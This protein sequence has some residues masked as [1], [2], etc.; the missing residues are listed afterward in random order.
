MLLISINILYITAVSYY[1]FKY[2]TK[3]E[4]FS[5]ETFKRYTIAVNILIIVE[6]FVILFSIFNQLFLL[7]LVLSAYFS[8]IPICLIVNILSKNRIIFS[9]K[10]AIGINL[11]TLF[12]TSG[13]VFYYSYLLTLNTFLVFVFPLLTLSLLLLLPL[14]YARN[15][16]V[17]SKI[18]EKLLLID[19]LLISGLVICSPIVI[20]LELMRIGMTIDYYYIL[21]TTIFLFFG[22]TRYLEYLFDK[23]KLKEIHVILLKLSQ[24]LIW[25]IASIIIS[26]GIFNL[27]DTITNNL[28]LSGSAFSLTFFLVNLIILMSL[29]NLKQRIFENETSKFDYYKIYKIYE[30]YKN[31]SFF[32]VIASIATLITFLVPS[33]I[34]LSLLQIPQSIA[35]TTITNVGIFVIVY[36]IVSVIGGRS[37]KVEFL[38]I[39]QSFEVLAWLFTK[40]LI[41]LYIFI[42]PIQITLFFRIIIPLVII[43]F[44]SPITI[45]YIRNL[46]FITEKTLKIIKKLNLYLFS[47]ALVA[48]FV[49]LFWEYSSSVLLINLNQIL[50]IFLLGGVVYLFFNFYIS[51]F[52]ALID[53][54]PESR[55]IKI[56]S[57]CSL[58]LFSF[59]SIFPN[60][61]EY[62]SYVLFF[63]VIYLML[64]NRTRN[65]ILRTISY[66]FLSSLIFIKVIGTLNIFMLLPSLIFPYF[67]FSLFLYSFSL[68]LIL[69]LS[70]VLNVKKANLIEKFALYFLISIN[71]LS[72]LVIYTMIPLIYNISIALFIFLLLTGNFFYRQKDERY[73]WFVR[74]CVLLL[75]YGLMS[76]ISYFFLFN[77]STLINFR[78]I[79]TFTLTATATGIAYVG[80]YNKT[81]EKFRRIT[82]YI[83]FSVY[84]VSFPVFM[85]FLL[86]GLLSL[87]IWD[88]FLFLIT[89][90][91]GIV[92]FY[93]SIGIYYWKFSW[94]IWKAGWRLWIIVPFVNFYLI[95]E[96]FTDINIYTNTLNFFN[97]L[98][99]N[100][101]FII[102]FVICI[103][104]SLP[105][106]YSWIK[107]HF[108]L[109][110]IIVWS[111]SLF[112]LYWFSQNIFPDNA[113]I[114]N[115]VF[116]VFAISLLVPL[117][118]RLRMW[119]VIAILWLIYTGINVTF[120]FTLF[121]EIGLPLEII[122]SI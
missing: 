36:L 79:L 77:N 88:T 59:F 90:N 103:L 66:M 2:G 4:L 108:T 117:I 116:V 106:W 24:I 6:S 11:I 74:P 10:S 118:Y 96:L 25:T 63:V 120:L 45:Y 94:G 58:V 55:M 81:P 112:F 51:K 71:C 70:I 46:V 9:D 111:F 14:F 69:F 87:P 101:S 98:S 32:G 82:F 64:S 73:K 92:L 28:W 15:K 61:I 114:T 68:T 85:Y 60:I 119:K 78:Q 12:F 18:V 72:L 37:I 39:K 52:D 54:A 33:H 107:N 3:L 104:L 8:T 40:F 53:R 31:I 43:I 16:N 57:G 100:G 80:T 113:V 95:N 34:F 76:Y 115:I 5:I 109:V 21:I 62:L 89:I 93:I 49:N 97:I 122:V 84:I 7:D 1:I 41:F 17:F 110:L 23:Y 102:S 42:L 13:L 50:Q 26:F 44:M 35:I 30:Y 47:L 67:D 105:F 121:S 75:I 83:A 86:N 91:I 19:S 56:F 27:I 99:I 65:Y 48:I 22:F 20:R 38:K 29:E